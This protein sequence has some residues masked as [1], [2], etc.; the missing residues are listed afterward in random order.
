MSDEA[1]LSIRELD[2]DADVRAAFPLMNL[3]RERL[4]GGPDAFLEQ[5]R[6]QE[7]EGYRLVGGYLGDRLVT[8][9]GVRR[10]HTLARGPHAFVDDLVTLPD[11]QGKGHATAL[12]KYIAQ[13]ALENGLPKL[14]LDARASALSYYDKLGFRFHTSVPC[15]IDARKFIEG[16]VAEASENPPAT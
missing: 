2:T 11:E 1:V 5:I 4:R 3:L 16:T 15:W 13:R 12:L 8:L 6:L 7:L 9:A 10:Q 14:H